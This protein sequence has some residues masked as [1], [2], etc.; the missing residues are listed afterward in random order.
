[1]KPTSIHQI[2]S[3]LAPY[4]GAWSKAEVLHLLRRTMFGTSVADLN[5]FKTRTLSQAVAE[6]L[7]APATAPAP[8]LND[9]NS[10]TAIDPN[11]AAGATWVNAPANPTMN[12]GRQM[13]LRS[14]W[15]GLQIAQSRSINEKMTL[16]WHNHFATSLS[17]Y[18]ESLIGYKHTVLLRNNALGN[19]KTLAPI[20]A[21]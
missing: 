13:S 4:S 15:T 19:F 17:I 16:F 2:Q 10:Q 12:G 20:A 9:Y 18:K 3:G 1:M 21:A 8:P 14:W 6:L 11:V 5:Y 7:T